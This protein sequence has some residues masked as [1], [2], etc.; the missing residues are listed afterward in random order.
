MIFEGANT[1]KQY[2]KGVDTYRKELGINNLIEMVILSKEG[3]IR[4]Y[5]HPSKLLALIQQKKR[6]L[7]KSGS[8]DK[9][10]DQFVIVFDRDS[11]ET[12]E[13]Y[14]EF[15]QL[16]GEE[17]IL[18]ITSPCFEIWLILHYEDTI[19]LY[20][21]P[22]R[23]KIQKNEKVSKAHSYTSK[24]FSDLS[25]MNPKTALKFDVLKENVDRAIQAEKQLEQH[26]YR[27]G[28]VIGSNVGQLIEQMRNDPREPLL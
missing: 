8:Y 18:T 12:K 11:F 22:E 3:E 20:I 2:F 4:D 21:D 9:E 15:I 6:E 1:E 24:L 13:T 23:D 7:I 26:V 19:T 16:A 5:S 27:L 10:I 25:G 17:N 14:L 28:D